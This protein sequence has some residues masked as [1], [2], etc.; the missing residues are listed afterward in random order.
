MPEITAPG[1]NP[2]KKYF[3]QP[4]LYM[5]LP[6][7]GKYYPEG[8]L[9]PTENNEYPVFSMTA[10]DELAFKT[11]DALMNG[12]STVDVIQSCIPNIKNAWMMPSLDLDAALI[13]IRIATFGEYMTITSSVPGINETRDFSTDLRPLLEQYRD[14]E[15]NDTV[16]VDDFL[17]KIR[18]INNKEF[19]QSAIKTF[20]EE[21]VFAIVN[22]ENTS[23]EEKINQFNKSFK[24]LTELTVGM[25]L[26]SIQSIEIGEDKVTNPHQI[27]EFIENADRTFYN[28]VSSQIENEKSK[29]NI[30]PMKVMS[31]PEDIEKGAPESYE[32][33]IMFDQANFFA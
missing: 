31:D 19:T 33:P 27:K 23:D 21:R 25:M 8:A 14:I 30:P 11:A 15:F 9:E 4:K 10:K 5:T 28:L 13:A 12:Q 24:K 32:V 29:F 7:K 18:P 20:E 1:A 6:S 22:D 2:L 17:I 3:R 26:S 16:Y